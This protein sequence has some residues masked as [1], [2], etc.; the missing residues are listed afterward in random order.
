LASLLSPFCLK[1]EVVGGLLKRIG[2]VKT[3]EI[4]V[5]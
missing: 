4:E 3:H 5:S 2:G 1:V